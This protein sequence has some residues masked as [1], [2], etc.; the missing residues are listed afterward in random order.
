MST[1]KENRVKTRQ[2]FRPTLVV[3]SQTTKT[4]RPS[5]T[6]LHHPAAWQQDET[7]FGLWQ[8]HHLQAY[9]L[10]TSSLSRVIA[11]VALVDESQFDMVACHFLDCGGQL[12]HLRSILLIGR[13]DMQGQQMPQS[14]HR[15]VNF[16]AF[17]PCGCII[18]RA[19]SAFGT[20]L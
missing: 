8:L 9:S 1:A 7:T 3:T 5:K 11:R 14:I 18:G 16:S 19:M 13:G 20:R 6:A 10:I 17:G 15:D 2:C 4:S 12:A